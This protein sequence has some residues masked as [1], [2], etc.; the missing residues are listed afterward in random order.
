MGLAT[1][2]A[3]IIL[4]TTLIYAATVLVISIKDY[5]LTATDSF[6][7]KHELSLDEL[8]TDI[9]IQSIIYVAGNISISVKNSGKTILKLDY[10]DVYVNGTRIPRND[11]NRTISMNSTSDLFNPGL[12]DPDEYLNIYVNETIATGLYRID[13]LTQHQGKDAM[14]IQV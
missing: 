5:S 11:T 6:D 13:I 4:F 7:Q 10:I 9:D 14:N 8:K 1:V 3:Q 12:W 2:A